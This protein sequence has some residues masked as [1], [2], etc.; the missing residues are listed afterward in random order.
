MGLARRNAKP[1]PRYGGPGPAG[2]ASGLVGSKRSYLGGLS[3]ATLKREDPHPPAPNL[4]R[5]YRGP[6]WLQPHLP[7]RWSQ[8]LTYFRGY[9]LETVPT[10]PRVGRMYVSRPRGRAEEPLIARVQLSDQPVVTTVP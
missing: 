6:A 4:K 9:I 8:H 7:S 1:A 10:V 5:A 2:R 3:W